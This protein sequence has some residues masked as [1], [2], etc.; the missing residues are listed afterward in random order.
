MLTAFGGGL[1]VYCVLHLC[2]EPTPLK[3]RVKSDAQRTSLPS[4]GMSHVPDGS[5]SKKP[6][7]GPQSSR[8]VVGP[9]QFHKP[10]SETKSMVRRLPVWVESRTANS[11]LQVG[12]QTCTR[13]LAFREIQ[14]DLH[15]SK[16]EERFSATGRRGR[17]AEN[18]A[19]RDDSS[20]LTSYFSDNN[21][22]M[23]EKD[24]FEHVIHII[25]CQQV[26]CFYG[27]AG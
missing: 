25:L 6:N 13:L 9:A 23:A 1:A 4:N 22:L 8:V 12:T 15:F 3:G 2:R 11:P 20:A 10:K 19:K 14:R 27:F 26:T 21:D 16:L 18:P 17:F 7:Q 5:I 24:G